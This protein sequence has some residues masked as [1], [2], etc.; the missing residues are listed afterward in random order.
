MWTK[1]EEMQQVQQW[2]KQ[3]DNGSAIIPHIAA[4]GTLIDGS[5]PIGRMQIP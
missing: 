1:V 4:V 3:L 5:N 2:R